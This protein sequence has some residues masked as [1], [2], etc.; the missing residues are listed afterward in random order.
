MSALT[1]IEYA[2]QASTTAIFSPIE[3]WDSLQYCSQKLCSE[4]GEIAGKLGKFQLKQRVAGGVGWGRPIAPSQLT[5]EQ[6]TDLLAEVGD[7]LWYLSQLSQIL[8]DPEGG[9]QGL[10]AVAFENVAL[11]NLQKLKAR[12]EAGTIVGH[13]DGV[14]DRKPVV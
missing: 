12:A 5:R 9:D 14:T 6:R 13:G 8:L 7:C 3:G 1:F 4:A 10:R 2:A 11:A